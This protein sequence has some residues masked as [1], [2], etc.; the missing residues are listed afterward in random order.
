[1]TN[2]DHAASDLD[3]HLLVARQIGMKSWLDICIVAFHPKGIGKQHEGR[4]EGQVEDIG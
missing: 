2:M 3:D 1:M 4:A